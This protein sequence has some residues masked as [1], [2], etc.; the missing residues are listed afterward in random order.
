MELIIEG[1]ER[2]H[3]SKLNYAIAIIPACYEI[4]YPFLPHNKLTFIVFVICTVWIVGMV[5]HARYIN[6]NPKKD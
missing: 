6:W 4:S 3:A 5:A 2:Y 1:F